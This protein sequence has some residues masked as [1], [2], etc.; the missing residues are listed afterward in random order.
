MIGALVLG[1]GLWGP[2]LKGWQA[3]RAVLAG[4]A[5]F[6]P[7]LADPPPPALLPANERRRAGPAARLALSVAAEA[8]AGGGISPQTLRALFVS[9]NGEGAV[10]NSLLATLA[11]QAQ[12]SG[13]GGGGDQGISPTLFHN[14]V[15]N[16]AAGYWS[17][18]QGS[19]APADSLAAHDAGFAIGLLKALAEVTV[20]RAPVL[21]CLFDAPMPFPL[22]ACR[23]TDFSFATALLLAPL[24]VETGAAPPLARLQGA[25][26]PHPAPLTRPCAPS[27]AHLVDGNPAAQ[28]LALLE[29]L[30]R[31][32]ARSLIA[33]LLD[34]HLAL[35]ITPCAG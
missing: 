34:G 16:E 18:G 33:P 17:I 1:V 9:S 10:V 13:G 22:S 2:G 28:S 7:T 21:F 14:S 12:D 32:E 29:A 4:T 25:F 6:T 19:R 8:V 30:A 27:F 23:R 5:P 35:E 24:S 26:V 20:E 31:G 3:G 15:H 11:E